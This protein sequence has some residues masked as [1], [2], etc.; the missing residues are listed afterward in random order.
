MIKAYKYKYNSL[1]R[2]C[3]GSKELQNELGLNVYNYQWRDYD[4]AKARFN[5][6]DRF[7]EKYFS[8]SPYGFTK[9]NPIRYQEIAGDSLWISFGKNNENKVL[10]QDGNLTNADGSQ[11][12]GTGVKVKKNGSIK[13]KNSFLKSAV[14]ELGKIS[15][16]EAENGTNVVSTLQSSNNN[17]TIAQNFNHYDPGTFDKPYL[18]ANNTTYNM[19]TQTGL[20]LIPYWDASKMGYSLQ[21][22]T[23]AGSGG[24]IYFDGASSSGV[25]LGHEMFHAFDGNTGS[26]IHTPIVD[27]RTHIGGTV[28]G[29][30][31]A[32]SFGNSI[33][34]FHNVKPLRQKYYNS[35]SY[36]LVN[37]NG[38]LKQMPPS[39]LINQN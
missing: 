5:N 24:I 36:N 31:R 17:F 6:I 21:G 19:T 2:T 30:I 20:K 9:N 33:R 23:Q 28:I 39:I 11:Y 13:I 34:S 29:E 1:S 8:H 15:E 12:T 37:P 26:L 35:H 16:A 22:A 32:S 14:R 4:P 7:A 10:Y 25:K 18:F 27:P 38:S 3:V